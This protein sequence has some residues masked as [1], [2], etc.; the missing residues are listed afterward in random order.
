MKLKQAIEKY[1][2]GMIYYHDK[3][4]WVYY[5]RSLTD[6]ELSGEKDVPKGLQVSEGDDWDNEFRGY[7]PGIV[8]ELAELLGIEVESV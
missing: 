5:K 1:P 8:V 4:S 2:K 7:A 3:Q 6:E